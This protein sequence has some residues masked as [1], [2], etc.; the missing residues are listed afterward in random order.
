[1]GI[2][3]RGEG[4]AL[5]TAQ[6]DGYVEHVAAGEPGEFCHA[7]AG[8]NAGQGI[9]SGTLRRAQGSPQSIQGS[10]R[11]LVARLV[12]GQGIQVVACHREQRFETGFGIERGPIDEPWRLLPERGHRGAL[13]LGHREERAARRQ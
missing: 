8:C 12:A 4:A 5:A 3:A 11:G 1:M 13:P 10:E 7:V 2:A 6:A 9:D